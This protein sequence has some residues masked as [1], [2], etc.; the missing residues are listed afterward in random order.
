MYFD[1]WIYQDLD[2][3]LVDKLQALD[4]YRRFI[5]VGQDMCSW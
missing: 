4:A 5:E 2:E 1:E 3:L